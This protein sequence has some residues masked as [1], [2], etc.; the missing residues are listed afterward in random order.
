[1]FYYLIFFFKQKTAYE[2][3]ISDWS[4]D[5]CSSDLSQSA[6]PWLMSLKL[7]ATSPPHS[8]TAPPQP[9]ITATYCSPSCSQVTG[10]PTTPEPVWNFHNSWPVFASKALRY[11][12]GVPVK[13]RLPAVESTPPQIGALFFYYQTILP[14]FG[15]MARRAP[16]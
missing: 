3:R 2:M 15:S 10:L 4:S 16:I 1:M 14:V 7:L 6:P 8:G 12:S 5:V 13:T 9:D 11:P